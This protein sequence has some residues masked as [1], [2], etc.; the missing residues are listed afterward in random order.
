MAQNEYPGQGGLLAPSDDFAAVTPDDDADLERL[1][2]YL[3]IGETGGALVVK[4]AAG[5]TVTFDVAAGQRV[6]IRPHRVMEATVADV[7]AVY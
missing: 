5:D 4:N 7:L 2:K 3:V 6:D 1:P